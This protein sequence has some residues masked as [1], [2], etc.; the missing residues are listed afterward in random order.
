MIHYFFS[1]HSC[2]IGCSIQNWMPMG[3]MHYQMC[4]GV[5]SFHHEE[6]FCAQNQSCRYVNVYFKS[7]ITMMKFF[8]LISENFDRVTKSLHISRM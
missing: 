4:A 7:I 2:S 6:F 3:A 8:S 1:S 5:K